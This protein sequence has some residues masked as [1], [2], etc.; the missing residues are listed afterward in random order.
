MM[1]RSMGSMKEKTPLSILLV[2]LI[3]CE[4]CGENLNREE[5]EKNAKKCYTRHLI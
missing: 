2:Q 1:K 4:R 3:E 5:N